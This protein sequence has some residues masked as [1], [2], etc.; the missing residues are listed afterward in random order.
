MKSS[1]PPQSAPPSARLRAVRS[2]LLA[3][4]TWP[5]PP[6]TG[7]LARIPQ[8][9]KSRD[10][11]RHPR[12]RHARG[13]AG[14]E[15]RQ[16]LPPFAPACRTIR[17]RHD[18]QP[19]LLV[20]PSDHRARGRPDHGWVG[21][22]VHHGRRHGKSM[23]YVPAGGN[24]IS[25]NPWVVDNNPG[26]YLSMG[27]TA[28]NVAK[29]YGITREE[30]DAFCLRTRT[31]KALAA[32]AAGTFDDEIVPLD[33]TSAVPDAKGGKVKPVVPRSSPKTKA[34]APTPASKACPSSAPSSTPRA[35]SRPATR[36]RPLTGRRPRW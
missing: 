18:G 7:A 28:E 3:P 26:S 15:R 1:S 33:V 32:Q 5:P 11:G 13:R 20:R 2:A 31:R 29:H 23:S 4:T 10:R 25:V 35:R 27:L 30:M 21:S 8:L 19:L 14:H 34:R 36:H 16:E 24:K 17:L 22:D 6:I 12:L 9:D